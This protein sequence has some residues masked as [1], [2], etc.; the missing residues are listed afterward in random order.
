MGFPH[1]VLHVIS[2][3]SLAFTYHYQRYFKFAYFA[4]KVTAR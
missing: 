1:K 3:R 2:V 4:I